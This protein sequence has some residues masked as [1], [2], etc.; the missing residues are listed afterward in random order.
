MNVHDIAIYVIGKFGLDDF[1]SN[2]KARL[3][4]FPL[5]VFHLLMVPLLA[6]QAG[7]DHL[8]DVVKNLPAAWNH[9]K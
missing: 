3:K 7:W 6:I 9:N 1:D 8:K 4:L 5:T 2:L